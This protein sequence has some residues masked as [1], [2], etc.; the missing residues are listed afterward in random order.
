MPRGLEDPD[1]C[2]NSRCVALS[3][4]RMNGKRK[5]NVKNRVSVALLTEKPPQS[6][7]TISLPTTGIAEAKLVITVAPQKDICP[8]GSTYP[9]NAV[10][11][12]K[13]RITTPIT[14][15]SLNW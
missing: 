4:A 1:W 15:V 7:N 11:I 14:H 12:N 6:Q 3:A 2:K 8:H 10:P 5:C 9:K 13:R